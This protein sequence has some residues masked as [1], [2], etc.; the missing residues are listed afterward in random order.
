MNYV[1]TYGYLI[2]RAKARS[3]VSGYFERH[4]VVPRSFGG[5]EVVKL[6]AREHFLA[7]WLLFKI[8]HCPTTAR[9]YRLMLHGQK[10]RRGRDY[11]LARQ[12]MSDS[13]RG[14]KN[15]AKRPE[16][17]QRI[18]DGLQVSHPFR[19]KKRPYHSL[20]MRGRRTGAANPAYG[21]GDR[22]RGILNASAKAV[23][24]TH[25]L[26]GERFWATGTDTAKDLGVSPAAVSSALVRKGCS[27]GW[28]LEYS[29]GI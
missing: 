17:R 3:A 6:T 21:K 12:I 19:G 16:V 15:V 26:F 25:P 10:R 28:K 1:R 14:D 2:A 4:H 18:R 13:M 11:A 5:T 23:R 22:Q 29:S 9:A 20:Y 24:G 8:H 27:R 7:H